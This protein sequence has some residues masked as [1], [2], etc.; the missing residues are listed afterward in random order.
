MVKNPPAIQGIRVW[1]LG[2]EDPLEKG[3]ATH[4]SILAWRIPWTE[5]P[6]GYSPWNHK[7]SDTTEQLTVSLSFF[8]HIHVYTCACAKLL[9]QCMTLCDPMDYSPPGFSVHGKSTLFRQECWSDLP[10]PSPWHHV[11]SELST[12]T[13]LK[14][15]RRGGKNTEKSYAKKN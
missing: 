10:F 4:S 14:I 3:M 12:T 7:E 13:H 5:L 9:Q 1:S 11:L 8:S 6:G 2:Q 15:L